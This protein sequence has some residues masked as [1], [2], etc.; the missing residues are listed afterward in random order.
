MR[1]V[2]RLKGFETEWKTEGLA[3]QDGESRKL[4]KK[5]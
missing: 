4:I 2:R 1:G 5:T 3:K